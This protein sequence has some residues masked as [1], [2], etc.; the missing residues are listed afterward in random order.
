MRPS[1]RGEGGESPRTRPRAAPARLSGLL[2]N[3]HVSYL[4]GVVA[5]AVLYRGVAEIGYALNF[6]GPVAAIAWLPVG[7][8]IAFL[9]LGG[10]RYWPGVLIGDL[11]ANDYVA[12]PLGSALGQTFGNLL[13]VLAATLLLR[14]LVPGGDPLGSVAG[15]GRMLVA[16]GVG[17]A[18]SAIVGPISMLLGDVIQGDELPR[19]WRT[20]WLGD[21]SGAL[22]V[23]PLALAWATP[24][25]GECGAGGR[26]R[27][28]S[29]S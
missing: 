22:I 15:L 18:V 8:G 21:A 9:Y 3:R 27:R 5:L 1:G 23:L 11:L 29:C 28:R 16:V 25:R 4:V 20:W 7:V 19:V 2:A 24:P 12:L 14:R 13:E 6:A 10:L 26:S 17:T